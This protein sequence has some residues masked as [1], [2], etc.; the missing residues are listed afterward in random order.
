MKKTILL[1]MLLLG[2]MCVSAAPYSSFVNITASGFINTTTINAG[3]TNLTCTQ[4]S[5][6][7]VSALTSALLRI[8]SPDATIIIASNSS[9]ANLTINM[10]KLNSTLDTRYANKTLT[11]SNIST[12]FSN[13]S[14]QQT[15]INNLLTENSSLWS[16]ASNQQT[17][18]NALVSSNTTT[19]QRIDSI[20][21]LSNSSIASLMSNT[22]IV[23]VGDAN[24]TLVYCGNIT[25]ATSNLCTITGG[26]SGGNPFDQ[27]L[28]TTSN[29]T[30]ANITLTA[31]G[32]IFGAGGSIGGVNGNV[33]Y[34]NNS[35]LAGASYVQIKNGSLFLN[36][37]TEPVF[38]NDS[39]VILYSADRNVE[40]LLAFK[41]KAGY[42]KYVQPH[43]AYEDVAW[44]QP[45]HTAVATTAPIAM[46]MTVVAPVG[47]VAN[48]AITA[49]TFRNTMIWS[50]LVTATTNNS[51][52]EWKG[53]GLNW[54]R[55]NDSLKQQNGG[56]KAVMR[57]NQYTQSPAGSY[58]C[59]GMFNA[60]SAMSN[61]TNCYVGA[62][63][64]NNIFVG[65][66]ET[67]T[68]LGIW[69]NDA[70]GLP[71]RK[72]DC[73][74]NYP[75]GNN[76]NATDAVYESTIF[77][78]PADGGINSTDVSVYVKRLDNTSITPCYYTLTT[79]IPA[80]GT[81]LGW[82]IFAGNGKNA[83]ATLITYGMNKVY[84]TR[85]N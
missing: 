80:Q 66:N 38:S 53:A 71:T 77:A 14:N 70:S 68:T 24:K 85:D 30:F 61:T 33:Q 47:T 58:S 4:I 46:G 73:G 74:I 64:T 62:F 81:P 42:D 34:N 43:L 56:F 44:Y 67:Q 40:N 39:G 15:Q 69:S 26:S 52:I 1:I 31:G 9:D 84:I 7:V 11:E 36:S 18:I 12:L 32:G 48:P 22:T 25:G 49:T 23:R 60:V 63:G 5:G 78:R 54:M 6:C 35:N 75:F 2:A 21:N 55:G 29:V 13:A 45:A 19:N 20:N 83:V 3:S 41:G 37:T 27:V 59:I 79:D 28:N 8:S 76:V 82:H 51:Y 16:N 17:T 57:F 72:Q 50:T 65:H 10:T